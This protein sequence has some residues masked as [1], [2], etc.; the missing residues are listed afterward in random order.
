MEDVLQMTC[1]PR[2]FKK[3]KSRGIF[4]VWERPVRPK[5]SR[6]AGESLGASR[7]P[8]AYRR[9]LQSKKIFFLRKEKIF[10]LPKKKIFFLFKEKLLFLRNKNR[11]LSK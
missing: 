8:R 10:F 2:I 1:N 4:D 6:R 7:S 11:V 9:A 5:G 3:Q